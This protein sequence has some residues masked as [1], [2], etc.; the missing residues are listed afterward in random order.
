[1]EDKQFSLEN[2]PNSEED[3]IIIH[4]DSQKNTSANYLF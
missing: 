4:F 1:M 2:R 3:L